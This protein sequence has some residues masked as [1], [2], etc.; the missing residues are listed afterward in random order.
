MRALALL[1][2]LTACERDPQRSPP[3]SPVPAPLPP[4]P[5]PPLDISTPRTVDPELAP[6]VRVS[7]STSAMFVNGTLI[8]TLDTGTASSVISDTL[9]DRLPKPTPESR[10]IIAADKRVLHGTVVDVMDG[11]KTAGYSRIAIESTP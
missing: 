11:L 6:T 2:L 3:P 10:A 4:T 5:T 7:I 1:C 9:V 8:L